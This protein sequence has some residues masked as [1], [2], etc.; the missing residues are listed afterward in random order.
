M[1]EVADSLSILA[2]RVLSS[3]RAIG[4]VRRTSIASKSLPALKAF[5]Q[6]EQFYR[7]GLWD[8]ALTRYDQAIEADSTFALALTRMALVLGWHPP[9]AGAYRR[10][11]STCAVRPSITTG[12]PSWTV[13]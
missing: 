13:S 9:T 11:G 2:L 10:V 4:S 3:G 5:L 6:A 1:G 7:R 8:S 12:C